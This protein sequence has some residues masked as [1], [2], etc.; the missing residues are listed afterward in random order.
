MSSSKVRS[1]LRVTRKTSWRPMVMPGNSVSRW[2]A[3]TCSSGTTR[4][5]SGMTTK[6]GSTGGTFTRA[7]R[8]SPVTGS[9]TSTT[10]LSERFEM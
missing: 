2:A 3:M 1:A 7:M 4:S 5:P 9:P 10:R 8:R 6:R